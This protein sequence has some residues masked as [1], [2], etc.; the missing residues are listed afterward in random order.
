MLRVLAEAQSRALQRERFLRKVSGEIARR[1]G[2]GAEG[3]LLDKFSPG[4]ANG[5]ACGRKDVSML[6]LPDPSAQPS[7]SCA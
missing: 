6:R 1:Y 3:K 5:H 2:S 7:P 4:V